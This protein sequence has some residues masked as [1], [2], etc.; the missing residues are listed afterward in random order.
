MLKL[1]ESHDIEATVHRFG[2][3]NEYAIEFPWHRTL[4]RPEHVK[5]H[6]DAFLRGEFTDEY[7]ALA[8]R[9]WEL[10]DEA[11]ELL[12]LPKYVHPTIL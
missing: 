8:R 6:I 2:N 7:R 9:G 12:G 3:R 10:V 1:A 5:A 11:R 4:Y